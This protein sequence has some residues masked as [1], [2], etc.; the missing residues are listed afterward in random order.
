M[1]KPA[2]RASAICRISTPKVKMNELRMVRR[3]RKSNACEKLSQWTLGGSRCG[4]DAMASV[5]DISDWETR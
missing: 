1:A 4:G 5:G 3:L 2:G